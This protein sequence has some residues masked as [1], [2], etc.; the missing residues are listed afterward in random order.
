MHF[1][2]YVNC[3]TPECKERQILQHKEFDP[4]DPEACTMVAVPNSWEAHCS[5]CRQTHRYS[6]DDVRDYQSD[7]APPLGF[8]NKV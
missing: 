7:E 6:V 2:V 4:A 3:K 1:Y 8:C 5:A